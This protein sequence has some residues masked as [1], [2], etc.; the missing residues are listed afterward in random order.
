[1]STQA[2]AFLRLRNWLDGLDGG[3]QRCM[4]QYELLLCFNLRAQACALIEAT[5]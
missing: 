4:S 1:M 5:L 2:R 3:E